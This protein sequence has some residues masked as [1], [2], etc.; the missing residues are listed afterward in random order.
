MADELTLEQLH[1]I[2]TDPDS[3]KK[4]AQSLQLPVGSYNSIPELTMNLGIHPETGR[5]SARYF[6]AFNG[7][8][9]VIGKAGR[10]GFRVSWEP[11]Y[12]EEGRADNQTKLFL[13][14]K[15]TYCKAVGLEED[16]VVGIPDVLNFLSKY[17]VNVRLLQGDTDNFA[18]AIS[19][20]KEV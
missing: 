13:Q 7:T 14:A 12:N 3:E 2:T 9:D 19:S 4:V 15:K 1:G 10:A 18:V 6:G 20:A 11:V 8:G 17:S 5:K 16:A